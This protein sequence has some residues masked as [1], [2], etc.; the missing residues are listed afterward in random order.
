MTEVEWTQNLK[1]GSQENNVLSR[2]KR[3]VNFDYQHGF[4]ALPC[5]LQ[6]VIAGSCPPLATL[7]ERIEK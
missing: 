5:L 4:G 1:N 2:K 7:L 6:E 3:H